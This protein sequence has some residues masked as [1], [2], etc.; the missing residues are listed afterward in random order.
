MK[1]ARLEAAETIER[2]VEGRSD[3][4]EWDDFISRPADDPFIEKIRAE[5]AELPTRFPAT[6][7]SEYC[8]EAGAFRL[9]ELAAHLRS[10]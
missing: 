7:P 1:I 10:P 5:C 9:K 6:M 3:A 4:Y 2:F 8:N